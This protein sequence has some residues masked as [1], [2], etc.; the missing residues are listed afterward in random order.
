MIS[1][2][3]SGFTLVELIMTIVIL[4]VLAATAL[5]RFAD[6]S[7]EA[8]G[9]VFETIRANFATAVNLVHSKSLIYKSAAGYPDVLLEGSCI[10][11]DP[12]SGYPVV[13]Q[14]A[15]TCNAVAD[16]TP[17]NFNRL[18]G[19]LFNRLFA[20]IHFTFAII[21]PVHAAPPPPPPPPSS[22]A[23]P[24]LLMDFDFND[25]IWTESTPTATLTSPEGLSF[26]YN[27]NTGLVN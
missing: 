20:D 25:W 16:V 14:A 1:K 12:T 15:A 21:A 23:L 26:I 22:A 5:P 17:L 27:Q 10:K 7:S 3:Q 9:A 2:P 6:L 19:A 8:E 11:I 18:P 13:D 24:N 4:G